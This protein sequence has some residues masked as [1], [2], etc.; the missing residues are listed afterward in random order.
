MTDRYE[1]NPGDFKCSPFGIIGN[2]WMEIVAGHAGKV[3]AMTASWGGL[4]VMWGRNVAYAVIRPQRFTKQLVDAGAAFSL[5]FL[6]PKRYREQQNYLGTASGR[7]EDK[8]AKARLEVLY[9]DG[10]PYLDAAD[11]VLICKKL[12]ARPFDPK[13]FIDPK[14]DAEHYA[15]SDHHT[16]YIAEVVRILGKA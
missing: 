14:V 3:N 8:L 15:E 7:Y 10:V 12:Y 2:D 16:L 9:V 1:I 5:N 4:G 13:S 11:K 6:D